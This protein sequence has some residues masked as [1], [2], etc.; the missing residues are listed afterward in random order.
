MR[1][2]CARGRRKPTWQNTV[3][4]KTVWGDDVREADRARMSGDESEK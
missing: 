1:L 3:K 2:I 4:L